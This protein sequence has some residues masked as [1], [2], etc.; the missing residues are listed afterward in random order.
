MTYFIH[1]RLNL[2]RTTSMIIGFQ[3]FIDQFGKYLSKGQ[4]ARVLQRNYFYILFCI[5]AFKCNLQSAH[6]TLKKKHLR[7]KKVVYLYSLGQGL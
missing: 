7:F 5:Y 3:H 1:P 6:F 4:V 2:F